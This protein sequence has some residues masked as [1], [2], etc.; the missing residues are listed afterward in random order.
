MAIITGPN[1]GGKSTFL[2]QNALIA[3]M[4]Q[5]GSWVPAVQ[6]SFTPVDAVWTRMGAGDNLLKDQSTFML[7]MEQMAKILE[8]ATPR[9]FLLLD[10]LGRGTEAEEGEALAQAIVLRL[11]RLGCRTLFATHFLRLPARLSASLMSS[12]NDD[13]GSS[14]FIKNIVFWKTTVVEDALGNLLAVVPRI[15]PGVAEKAWAVAI[16]R[17][18]GIPEDVLQD[19][20]CIL[21][22]S[23]NSHNRSIGIVPI[24]GE[25]IKA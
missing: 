13:Q 11:L 18:A 1:M 3:V 22:S 7:E 24:S 16:G 25:K 8:R 19:A 12:S 17:M 4:A 6:C 10:E 5:A 21:H 23:R 9:S 2:R 14:N 15:Q 20:Q